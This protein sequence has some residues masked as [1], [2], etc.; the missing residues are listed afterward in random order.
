MA[1]TEDKERRIRRLKNHFKKDLRTPK[2]QQRIINPKKVE[3]KKQKYRNY[4]DYE[5]EFDTE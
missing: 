2:Y 3:Y 4:E 5:V 1:S